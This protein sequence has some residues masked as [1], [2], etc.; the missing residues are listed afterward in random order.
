MRYCE[1]IGITADA[2]SRLFIYYG[3]ASCVGRLVTGR[4]CDFQ[5]VNT[6]YVYQV[7]ELVVGTGTLLVTMA[8]SYLHMVIYIVIYGF[9]DGVFITALNV[10]I[11]RCVSP[12]KTPIALSWEMQ[13]SSLFVASGPPIAGRFLNVHTI[14]YQSPQALWLAVGRQERLWDT[15][16]RIF[17]VKQY[18]RTG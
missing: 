4:L 17:A 11:L 6:F 12:E 13:M 9:C 7:A 18:Q 5:K 1:E 8:T 14:S 15:G 16:S 3:V 2:A 10:L